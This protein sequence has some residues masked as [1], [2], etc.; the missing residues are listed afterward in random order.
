[1]SIDPEGSSPEGAGAADPAFSRLGNEPFVLLTTFRKSGVGVATPVWIAHDGSDLLVTTPEESGK[2]KRVRNSGRVTLQPSTRM[3]KPKEGTPVIYGHAVILP[4]A[5]TERFSA[6]FQRK[7]GLEYRVFLVIE[8]VLARR[9]KK[10]V[11][12]R[13]TPPAL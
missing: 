7:Y 13:I 5:D 6:V 3:G 11:I 9:Q 10:R 4:D 1:M 12:L 8:R 2:V